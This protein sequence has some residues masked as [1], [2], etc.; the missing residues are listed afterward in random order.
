MPDRDTCLDARHR[1]YERQARTW[2]LILPAVARHAVNDTE[3]RRAHELAR[4]AQAH[5]G[6]TAWERLAGTG[7]VVLSSMWK[8][9]LRLL[10]DMIQPTTIVTRFRRHGA[11]VAAAGALPMIGDSRRDRR[12][13]PAAAAASRAG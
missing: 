11:A 9:R 6:L 4:R 7:T 3:R 10:G 13:P 12:V 1:Q 2:R 5:F 8:L